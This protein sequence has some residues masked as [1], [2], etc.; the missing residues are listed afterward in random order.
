MTD[1]GGAQVRADLHVEWH[2]SEP[3]RGQSLRVSMNLQ[4]WILASAAVL[5]ALQWLRG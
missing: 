3:G 5:G 1:A 2:R 4:L